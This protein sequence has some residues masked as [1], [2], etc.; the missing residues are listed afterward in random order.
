MSQKHEFWNKQPVPQHEIIFEK[1]G[2]I[3]HSRELKHDENKLPDGYK[4]SSCDLTELCEFLK[5]NYIQDDTFE[6]EYSKDLL[7]WAIHPPWYR[8]EWNIAIR[9]SDTNELVAFMSGIPLDIRV[10]DKTM[11]MLQIN[12]LCVSKQLRDSKFTPMLINEEKRRMN[13]QN[14]WQAAYTV[15]KFLPIPVSKITYFHR[16]IRTDKLN[17]LGFCEVNKHSHH[18]DGE[19]RFREMQEYDIPRVTK[20]L[21]NHLEKFKLSLN[22][23][24]EYV[25]HWIMP[26]KGTI[27]SYISNEEDKFLTFYSLNYVM[28]PNHKIIK[29]ANAFYNVGNCLQD[30]IILARDLGFDMYN[31]SNISVDEEELKKHGFVEGTGHNHYYLWNWKINQEIK[32]KDIGFVMI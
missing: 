20:M 13:L 30:A 5:Y 7:E 8:D 18:I 23:N 10:N 3:D 27:Y 12:F 24:E 31:C 19:T 2:E 15:T 17:E 22:I 11:R 16:L 9:K 4:W 32:P 29:Q 21:R 25:K 28:K 26:R 1:D 14:I 6:Y